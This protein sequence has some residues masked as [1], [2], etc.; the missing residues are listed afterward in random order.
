MPLQSFSHAELAVAVL[1]QSGDRAKRAGQVRTMPGTRALQVW[2]MVACYLGR[3]LLAARA[4][5]Y[6]RPVGG[7]QTLA[8][9]AS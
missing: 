9:A 4:S 2:A 8:A 7:G 1:L 3:L 6:Q 5:L